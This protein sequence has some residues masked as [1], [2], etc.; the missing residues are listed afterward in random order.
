MQMKH[1][2]NKNQ[3][4]QNATLCS[5]SLTHLPNY[6]SKTNIFQKHFSNICLHAFCIPTHRRRDGQTVGQI[7]KSREFYRTPLVKLRNDPAKHLNKFKSKYNQL[8]S[9]KN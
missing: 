7:D 1:R 5:Q 2:K 4:M 9:T 8:E 6:W 3:V